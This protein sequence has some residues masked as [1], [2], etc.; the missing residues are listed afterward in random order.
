MQ[1][2]YI[3]HLSFRVQND[4]SLSSNQV[5]ISK[6]QFIMYIAIVQRNGASHTA[7]I[8]FYSTECSI[9]LTWQIS[10]VIPPSFRD[11]LFIYS[12]FLQEI[13]L[14]LFFFGFFP[15]SFANRSRVL[16]THARRSRI[17]I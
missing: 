8:K 16:N 1:I 13:F 5:T 2:I 10:V 3:L 12:G 17:V 14:L 9:S 6:L 11:I 15:S 7:K 4:S